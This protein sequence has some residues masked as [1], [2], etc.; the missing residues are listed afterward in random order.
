MDMPFTLKLTKTKWLSQ[1][2]LGLLLFF[3]FRTGKLNLKFSNNLGTATL[4]SD[5]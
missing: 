4:M 3:I 5:V 2:K 1:C